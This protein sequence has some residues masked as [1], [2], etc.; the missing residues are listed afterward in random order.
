M[1]RYPIIALLIAGLL[2]VPG[3][4][5]C[6]ESPDLVEQIGNGSVNWTRG[7]I[8]ATGI[9]APLVKDFNKP[10]NRQKALAAAKEIAQRNLFEVV[11]GIRI[12]STTLV[13]DFAE[14]DPVMVK[15]KSMVKQA[16]IVKQEYLSDG[17]VEVTM[18]ISM[19]AGFSQLVLPPEI[20]QIE[21][22][23][24]I[25]PVQ[26]ASPSTPESALS[27]PRLVKPEIFTGL[28]VDV[29]ELMPDL[30]CLSKYLM[31]MGRRFTA[32]LLSAVNLLSST[33]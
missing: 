2:T 28:V 20:Q 26:K 29:R 5:Y 6:V 8:R 22:I 27:A 13:G 30:L 16:P 18:Q 9:K 15:V 12:N 31:K 25:G 19:Y 14:S 21:S 7:I 24:R 4:L 1:K 33:E 17:T 11:K 3:Y 32:R 23:R 10:G